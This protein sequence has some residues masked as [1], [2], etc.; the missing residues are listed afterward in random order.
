MKGL[1]FQG[2]PAA[3]IVKRSL[4]LLA[5]WM[6]TFTL[7]SFFVYIL[8]EGATDKTKRLHLYKGVFPN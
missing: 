4:V 3:N 1:A 8:C 5:V 7:H 6:K 2:N